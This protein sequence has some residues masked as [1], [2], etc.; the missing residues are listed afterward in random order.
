MEADRVAFT[1]TDERLP[2][3]AP[4]L[5]S[6]VHESLAE[7]LPVLAVRGLPAGTYALLIN[8]TRITSAEADA[9]AR[10]VRLKE[11]PARALSEAVR[12]E[13]NAKNA[14]FFYRWR[15]HNA[16]YVF[17]RRAKPFGVVSFPPE[18]QKFDEMIDE[19]DMSIQRLN[20]P[21]KRQH[22]ELVPLDK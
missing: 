22:W 17:G 13:I 6:I 16:E 19:K 8:G 11:T 7:Q 1:V 2:D 15:A 21:S 18:M 14:Q 4:P 10:G 9:W 3:P 12:A 5:G 20:R